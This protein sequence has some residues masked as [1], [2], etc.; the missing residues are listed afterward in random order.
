MRKYLVFG[1]LNVDHNYH[2][3]HIA[4]P[5]E[6][7]SAQRYTVA[8]GGKGLNQ[9]IALAKTGCHV[10]LAGVMGS[11]AELL[12]ETLAQFS[13]D[14]RFLKHVDSPNG[15]AVIQLDAAG[16]NSI[17]V[18]PGSNALVDDAYSDEV[19]SHFDAGDFL[20]LQNEISGLDHII[21]T[22][23][24]KGMVI[25]MNPSPI[26]EALF[27]LPLQYVDY[28]F[29][30]EVEGQAFTGESQAMRI[31]A[32]MADQY[33]DAHVI[34]TVGPQGAYYQYR[35]DILFRAADDAEPVD[36]VGAGDAFMGYFTYGLAQDYTPQQCLDI[37]SKAS[38]ITIT[39]PGA[40]ASIPTIEE[41][42]HS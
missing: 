40:A 7:I 34:L 16:Q 21:T 37:A 33:P 30:N 19:L 4:A 5:K 38:A 25:L 42:L 3:D 2:L 32:A 39:R 6:T 9:S 24:E 18:Y 1:S 28:L 17:I 41:V 20:V 13:V 14:T 23:H 35:H 11:G 22:A 29:I 26:S 15:H 36:T 10:Y 8:A 12:A 27:R 31:L